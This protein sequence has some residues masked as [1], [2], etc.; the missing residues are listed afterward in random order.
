MTG[1]SQSRFMEIWKNFRAAMIVV[2]LGKGGSTPGDK[3]KRLEDAYHTPLQST[4]GGV[5]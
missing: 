1:L 3:T 5:G 2:V 4:V